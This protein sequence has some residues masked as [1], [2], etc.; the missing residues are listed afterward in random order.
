VNT[1]DHTPERTLERLASNSATLVPRQS[2]V[3]TRTGKAAPDLYRLNLSSGLRDEFMRIDAEN[4]REWGKYSLIQYLTSRALPDSHLMW[5]RTDN[6]AMLNTLDL[7]DDARSAAPAFAMD[8]ATKANL[9]MTIT[10]SATEADD[11]RATVFRITR[12]TARLAR[13]KRLATVFRNGT[14]DRI[15]DEVLLFNHEIDAVATEGF[16]F[17]SKKRPFERS[18][19]FLEDLRAHAGETFEHATRQ[20][21][22]LGI[23]ELR[24][25]ATSDINM[26]AKM[27][28][29]RRK[30]EENPAY[31]AAMTM[32][33][34]LR[35]IDSHPGVEVCL[36]GE[37]EDRRFVFQS[38]PATR[39]KI[40]KL[41]DDDFLTSDLTRLDYEVDSKGDPVQ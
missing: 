32:P 13:S 31:A 27:A 18:F 28:S 20:L 16:V 17:F 30:L 33:N 41:L 5:V 3:V 9:K 11:F 19:E 25:A 39:Y 26:M 7:D 6:V 8:D 10:T 24:S 4:C 23:S 35:F 34:L 29:I 12:N 21:R 38:S 1:P 22:I 36:E 15:D 40:L 2:F 14:F 37:G